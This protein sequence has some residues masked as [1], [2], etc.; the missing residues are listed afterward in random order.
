MSDQASFISQIKE[1]E[2]KAAEMLKAVEAENDTRLFKAAEDA[3]VIVERA[4]EEE[5]IKAKERM[6]KAKEE[7]KAAYSKILVD[8]D[9]AR[10]DIIENG[11]TKVQKG[12]SQVIEAVVA[13]FE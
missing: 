7:A 10:R 3:E 8:A 12:K 5:L 9:N 4:E 13:M 1:A 11:K 6:T 2:E